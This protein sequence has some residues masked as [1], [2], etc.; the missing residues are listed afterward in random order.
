MNI[1]LL[2]S[3]ISCSLNH[4]L[5]YNI[6]NYNRTIKTYIDQRNIDICLLLHYINLCI[7]LGQFLLCLYILNS[8]DHSLYKSKT[9]SLVVCLNLIYICIGQ[10]LNYKVFQ[11]LGG[12]GVYYGNIFGKKI[13]WTNNFPFNNKWIKHPQYIGTWLTYMGIGNLLKYM[14]NSFFMFNHI[15]YLQ[16]FITATYIFTTM[17]EN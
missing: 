2:L 3:Y 13:E 15:T 5:Y 9:Y 8:Y 10:F 12:Y 11:E 7:K 6:L 14:I 1:I 4:I 17:T 16:L